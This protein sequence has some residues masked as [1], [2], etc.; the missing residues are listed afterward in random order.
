MNKIYFFITCIVAVGIGF[1][2]GQNIFKTTKLNNT[3]SEEGQIIGQELKESSY[4]RTHQQI[5]RN[6]NDESTY[7][8]SLASAES[9]KEKGLERARLD[10]NNRK[11]PQI[12]WKGDSEGE[13][14]HK[15]L[16]QNS[17]VLSRKQLTQDLMS[18]KPKL[19]IRL[20]DAKT[21]EEE[22]KYF[23]YSPEENELYDKYEKLVQS[24][25]GEKEAGQ[26]YQDTLE[27]IDKNEILRVQQFLLRKLLDSRPELLPDLLKDLGIDK[28]NSL[29]NEFTLVVID[30]NG[31]PSIKQLIGPRMINN[32]SVVEERF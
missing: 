29:L 24:Y 18:L 28:V 5:S 9:D 8:R 3:I 6:K 21:I 25:E 30:K 2:I 27:L 12:I 4:Q 23:E 10:S 20:E 19:L 16:N 17:N 7:Q 11:K 32:K 1:S 15:S 26:L 22:A 31:K 13:I 14:L